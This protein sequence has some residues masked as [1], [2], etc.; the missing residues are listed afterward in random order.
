MAVTSFNRKRGR[1]LPDSA[2]VYLKY[3][4]LKTECQPQKR[5]TAPRTGTGG[6]EML[7]TIEYMHLICKPGR[8]IGLFLFACGGAGAAARG[9]MAVLAWHSFA[10][11]SQPGV[12]WPA[13]RGVYFPSPRQKPT[14]FPSM[15]ISRS[16]SPWYTIG[17]H[18]AAFSATSW[19]TSP[20]W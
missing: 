9:L 5:Y 20:D 2:L 19:T 17:G 4:R 14:A 6:N 3:N 1:P 7:R 13:E 15:Q 11:R 10:A 18:T 8:M 16:C 12:H